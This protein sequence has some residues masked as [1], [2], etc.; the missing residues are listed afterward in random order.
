MFKLETRKL[1]HPLNTFRFGQLDSLSL[2]TFIRLRLLQTGVSL[3]DLLLNC[4]ERVGVC[5]YVTP[6]ILFPVKE[7]MWGPVRSIVDAEF[8]F[9]TQIV[10]VILL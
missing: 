5:R 9:K 2:L 7:M 3:P 8:L 6:L 4:Y 10:I 1:V